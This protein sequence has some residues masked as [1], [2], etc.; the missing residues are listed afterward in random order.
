M[1]TTSSFPCTRRRYPHALAAEQAM[2]ALQEKERIEGRSPANSRIISAP[3]A[4][5]RG[6]WDIHESTRRTRRGMPKP[7]FPGSNP[8]GASLASTRI[9]TYGSVATP[10]IPVS[11]ASSLSAQASIASHREAADMTQALLF[12]ES[13]GST[14][15]GPAPE[16][17]SS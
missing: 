11:T 13:A 4:A 2:A 7:L 14:V 1:R 12:R 16:Q 3:G 17:E 15:P 8:G 5:G 10:S 9:A 6:M